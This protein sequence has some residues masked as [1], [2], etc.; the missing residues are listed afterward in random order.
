MAARRR[1]GAGSSRLARRGQSIVEF[2][3]ALPVFLM[4]VFGTVDLGRV[5]FTY[6]GLVNGVREGA[7]FAKVNCPDTAAKRTAVANVVVDRTWTVTITTANVTVPAPA[8]CAP[9]NG[10]V[11]VSATTTF[12]TVAADFL[13]VL[14]TMTLS[15]SA[16]AYVE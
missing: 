13:G 3:L 14:P 7:R 2:G 5:V 15:A 4:V 8:S 10:F 11:D 9:P 6:V 16:R 12:D 1:G